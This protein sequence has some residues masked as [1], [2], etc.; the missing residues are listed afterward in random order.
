MRLRCAIRIKERSRDI[1]ERSNLNPKTRRTGICSVAIYNLNSSTQTRKEQFELSRRRRH[2][3]R[4][5]LEL[6]WSWLRHTRTKDHWVL[7]A[8]PSFVQ[9]S[10]TLCQL[11][12][13]GN[14]EIFCCEW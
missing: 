6:G 1:R 10:P 13:R 4:D 9:R 3:I 14:M 11:R 7:P 5:P 2:W 12:Y 8:R